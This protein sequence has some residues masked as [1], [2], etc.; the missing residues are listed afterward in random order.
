[1]DLFNSMRQADALAEE[2]RRRL[3]SVPRLDDWP[4]V[5]IVVVNRDG[6]SHLRRLLAGLESHTD[7]PSFEL[8]L[9]DNAS[10]DGSLDFIRSARTRFPISIVANPHNESFSDAQVQPMF[11]SQLSPE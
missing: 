11:A 10:G 9:V 6:L 4:L 5:S 2:A 7:Y 1:M 8:I 3:G